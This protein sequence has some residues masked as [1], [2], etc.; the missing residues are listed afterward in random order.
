MKTCTLCGETH[1]LSHYHKDKT[2]KDG[3]KTRCKNCIGNYT[4]DWYSANRDTALA[5]KEANREHIRERDRNYRANNPH[6]EWEH[7]YKR[8]ANAY[9]FT[10]IIKRFTREELIE[11]YGDSCFHCGGEWIQLDHFPTPVIRHGEHSL[12]NCVPSCWPCNVKSWR[13]EE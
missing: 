8:R 7:E 12:D 5:Y 4:R 1:P 6:L 3:H 13:N 11:R 2:R 9:G 10:P